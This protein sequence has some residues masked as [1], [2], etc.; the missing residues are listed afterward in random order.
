MTITCYSFSFDILPAVIYLYYQIEST[1]E[2]F[3]IR[4]LKGRF[5][6]KKI[7]IKTILLI[8][9]SLFN[10]NTFGNSNLLDEKE[11]ESFIRQKAADI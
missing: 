10:I 5:V 1:K 2:L 8:L 7:R 9:I 11:S 3:E 4:K 6:M